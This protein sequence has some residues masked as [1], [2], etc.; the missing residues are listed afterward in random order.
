V[1]HCNH[2]NELDAPV[3]NVL[4]AIRALGVTLLNQAVLLKNV[5][6]NVSAQCSLSESLFTAGVL[7]YYLHL[8]DPVQ[9]AAHFD[10]DE[11]AG[12]ALI[13]AMRRQ[14]PGFLMPQLVR[15]QAGEPYKT[16]IPYR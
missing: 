15:E 3:H 9:S 7:P 6:D 10:V 11:N 4:T 5:N 16:P 1:T 14:L 12:V 2:A 8:L 13:D